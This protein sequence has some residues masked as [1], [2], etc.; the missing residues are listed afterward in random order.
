MNSLALLGRNK[1]I[2]YATEHARNVS[3]LVALIV[4]KKFK[5]A[6]LTTPESDYQSIPKSFFRTAKHALAQTDTEGLPEKVRS[7]WIQ[8][9]DRM[10]RRTFLCC[11]C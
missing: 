7:S 2:L 6:D 11:S 10:G 8:Q 3:L 4:S 1:D 5:A 9:L